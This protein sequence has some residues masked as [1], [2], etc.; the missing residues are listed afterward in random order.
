ML[1]A[2]YIK[3]LGSS[4]ASAT[5]EVASRHAKTSSAYISAN[6]DAF[7][8]VYSTIKDPAAIRKN[9]HD[10]GK[11]LQNS[12]V[13]QAAE[14][15]ISNSLDTIITGKFYD[16]ERA[17]KYGSMALGMDM[18]FDDMNDTG[19]ADLDNL[20][21]NVDDFNFDEVDDGSKLV[22]STVDKSAR[23]SAVVISSTVANTGKAI[24]QSQK[25]ST[26][27]MAN[28]QA[29]LFSG[30]QM[31]LGEIGNE[32]KTLNDV[33][34]A[35]AKSH[36]EASKT[37]YETS[38]KLM[39]DQNAMIK[40]M[41][42]MQKMTAGGLEKENKKK[43][44]TTYSDLV[45]A[46]GEVNIGEYL[47]QVGN[48]F[49][50]ILGEV[51]LDLS[52][53]ANPLMALSAN[54][55]AFI[56]EMIISSAIGPK[57]S[58]S[59]KN[60]DKS[61]SGVFGTM[62]GQMNRM[63]KNE[64]ST[65]LESMFGK[66]FGVSTSQK[67]S[68]ELKNFKKGPVP[69]DSVA[70]N[71]LVEVIP[72]YLRRIESAIVG[73]NEILYDHDS[74]KWTNIE[75]VKK[76]W[77]NDEKNAVS[78]A[79]SDIKDYVD[80]FKRRTK[81]RNKREE[82]E[83][84]E[85]MIRMFEKIYSD[86]VF[87]PNRLSDT[88]YAD[89]GVK[90]ESL[91]FMKMLFN[92]LPKHL[93]MTLPGE[94]LE[95]KNRLTKSRDNMEQ[96][97]SIA[98]LLFDGYSTR[99][100]KREGY[101]KNVFKK[102]LSL[103]E[104]MWNVN[105]KK[106]NNAHWYMEN[107][108]SEMRT[109]RHTGMAGGPGNTARRGGSR[110]ATITYDGPDGRPVS[111]TVDTHN[112]PDLMNVERRAKRTPAEEYRYQQMMKEM[113]Y[114]EDK[115]RNMS[116]YDGRR[117]I[118][119]GDDEK[120]NK[121][122]SRALIQELVDERKRSEYNNILEDG[123]MWLYNE[124]RD[125]VKNSRNRIQEKDP[126]NEK[127][128]VSFVR[129]LREAET[130]GDKYDV[131]VDGVSKIL[132]K[133]S[134]LIVKTLEM[135]DENIY[136][137][138]YGKETDK[139]DPETG[140]PIHGFFDRMIFEMKESFRSLNNWID[141]NILDPLLNKLGVESFGD[142]LK[143]ITDRVF[144]EGTV[145]NWKENFFGENSFIGRTRDKISE[146]FQEALAVTKT[147]VTETFKEIKEQILEDD[148]NPDTPLTPRKTP[149]ERKKELVDKYGFSNQERYANLAS[150][151]A[152]EKIA[153]YQK[154]IDNVESNTVM[155]SMTKKEM[156]AN[157]EKKIREIENAR[158][159]GNLA[160]IGESKKTLTSEIEE[161]KNDK[162]DSE[163]Y[164][165]AKR[166]EELI[167]SINDSDR[168]QS[169]KDMLIRKVSKKYGKLNSKR[170]SKERELENLSAEEKRIFKALGISGEDELYAND[171]DIV[172]RIQN[173]I[174]ET[175]DKITNFRPGVETR[176]ERD[177]NGNERKVY[178]SHANKEMY[179]EY[180]Q[181]LAQKKELES[182]MKEYKELNNI[183]DDKKDGPVDLQTLL[184]NS[185][186][187]HSKY[188]VNS[189][190]GLLATLQKESKRVVGGSVPTKELS[191]YQ[192]LMSLMGNGMP[193]KE[194]LL[195]LLEDMGILET[196]DVIRELE[197]TKSLSA[198]QNLKTSDIKDV[199]KKLKLKSIHEKYADEEKF[200]KD[201]VDER[202]LSK[203]GMFGPNTT[204]FGQTA[205]DRYSP[206]QLN[207]DAV[208]DAVSETTGMVTETNSILKDIRDYVKSIYQK[209]VPDSILPD[210][211]SHAKGA[212]YVKKS[213]LTAISEGEMIIPSEMNPFNPNKDKVNKQDE[214]RNERRIKKDY[215][216]DLAKEIYQNIR[217]NA[218]GQQPINPEDKVPADKKAVMTNTTFADKVLDSYNSSFNLISEGLFGKRDKFNVAMDDIKSK[219]S[220]YLPGGIAGGLLGGVVGLGLGAPLVLAAGGASIALASQS[221]T[222]K[223][224]LF[225]EMGKDANG[226]DDRKGGFIGKDTQKIFNKYIPDLTKYGITGGL[227]GAVLGALGGPFGLIGGSLIGGSL[228][229][230]KNNEE[231][232]EMFFGKDKGLINDD[233]KKFLKEKLPAATA[234]VVGSLM[235]GSPFGLIGGSMLG[236]GIGLV[237][238]TDEFKD[239]MFGP[240]AADGVR[241]GGLLGDLKRFFV[242]PLAEI[243]KSI[244]TSFMDILRNR[245]VEPLSR[246]IS[247]LAKDIQLGFK[248]GFSTVKSILEHVFTST[249][250]V[251][252]YKMLEKPMKWASN[253][254]FNKVTKAV[255]TG[256]KEFLLSPATIIG[257]MGDAS[258]DRHIAR[259]QADYMTAAERLDFRTQE[260]DGY[261]GKF[262]RKKDRT[263]DNLVNFDNMLVTSNKDQLTEMDDAFKKIIQG[264]K[265]ISSKKKDATNKLG[266]YVSSVVRDSGDA[267][268]IIR[269]FHA[270]NPEEAMRIIDSLDY[271][272]SPEKQKLFEEASKLNE[273]LNQVKYEEQNITEATTK[274]KDTLNNKFNLNLTSKN[275]DRY[276]RYVEVEKNARISDEDKYANATDPV[277]AVID[278]QE[279]HTE[280]VA[281]NFGT[282][283]KILEDIRAGR[284]VLT[285]HQSDANNVYN[286]RKNSAN[287][288]FLR[289]LQEQM[290]DNS[291]R[292]S[293][294]YKNNI[295]DHFNLVDEAD[296]IDIMEDMH[297]RGVQFNSKDINKIIASDRTVFDRMVELTELGYTVSVDEV[298]KLTDKGYQNVLAMGKL[299][300]RFKDGDFSKVAKLDENTMK[301]IQKM[302]SLGF[303][304]RNL[305]LD[306][307]IALKGHR[308]SSD[309]EVQRA[310]KASEEA[311]YLSNSQ[312]DLFQ[313]TNATIHHNVINPMDEFERTEIT[314]L[315]NKLHGKE[316]E[317]NTVND[318]IG[319]RN[320]RL[321]DIQFK[322]TNN[323]SSLD[324][325]KQIIKTLHERKVSDE[326][327]QEVL[328]SLKVSKTEGRELEA[329][330]ASEMSRSNELENTMINAK[331]NEE[332]EAA[333]REMIES[334]RNVDEAI[335]RLQVVTAN[336]QRYESTYN[337][338]LEKNAESDNQ[339]AQ[340]IQSNNNLL[341]DITESK[342]EFEKYSED[343]KEEYSKIQIRQKEL[344]LEVLNLKNEYVD[345]TSN[346]TAILNS[347]QELKD[348]VMMEDSA[349]R[350]NSAVDA[351][352][353]GGLM[354]TS[355]DGSLVPANTKDAEPGPSKVQR[356]F[357]GIGSLGVDG[358]HKVFGDIGGKELQTKDGSIIHSNTKD[359]KEAM[360]KQEEAAQTQKT[361]AE[362]LG[363]VANGLVGVGG[364]VGEGIGKAKDSLLGG[365]F[366]LLSNTKS[367]PGLLSM[368]ALATGNMGNLTSGILKMFK[369][370]VSDGDKAA[371]DEFDRRADEAPGRFG[372]R[373]LKSLG[374]TGR[375][376][377][378]MPRMFGKFVEPFEN[379]A[380]SVV[381]TAD[382][383]YTSPHTAKIAKFV[384]ENAK[385]V[386]AY[387]G[388][389]VTSV[390]DKVLP[391]NIKPNFI[392]A[393]TDGLDNAINKVSKS[394]ILQ[395]TMEH[396]GR[397]FKV[398][399]EKLQTFF[400]ENVKNAF[401]K[402]STKFMQGIKS[403]VIKGP[404]ASVKAFGRVLV[405]ASVFLTP[406]LVCWDFINGWQDARNTFGIFEEP[407][408]GLQFASGLIRALNGFYTF[409]LVPESFVIDLVMDYICKPLGYFKELN[410]L[411]ARANKQLAEYNKDKPLDQQLSHKGF[412][413]Q[414]QG[415]K[416][417]GDSAAEMFETPNKD[418]NKKPGETTTANNNSDTQ[419]T[420][421]EKQKE[422]TKSN[423]SK[424]VIPD[425]SEYGAGKFGMG[426]HYY[427]HDPK[428]NNVSYNANYD[429]MNQT[430]G[431]SGC[432]VMAASQIFSDT[433]G[434]DVDPRTLANYAVNN[435]YKEPNGGT[436]P[437]FFSDVFSKAGIG[438]N[439]TEDKKSMMDNLRAGKQTILMGTGSSS[440]TPFGNNPHY[441]VGKGIDKNGNIII[442]D[443]ESRNPYQKYNA[444]NVMKGVS[445]GVNTA[446]RFGQGGAGTSPK[447]IANAIAGGLIATG[448]EGAVDS[449]NPDDMGQPSIGISQW[450]DTRAIQLLK[451]IPGGTEFIPDMGMPMGQYRAEALAKVLANTDKQQLA[452][453]A[454]DCANN[455]LP[456]LAGIPGL[457]NGKCMVY[458]GMW[459]PTST[460]LVR[461]FVNNRANRF[462][463]NN[464]DDVHRMFANEYE[465][466]A[467]V[468]SYGA[469]P[470]QT[471]EYC[472]KLPDDLSKLSLSDFKSMAKSSGVSS[473]KSKKPSLFG[474]LDGIS[475]KMN[476]QLENVMAP[477]LTGLKSAF[478]KQY[479]GV[480]SLIFGDENG[481]TS[482]GSTS[483]TG[484][485]TT[486][487]QDVAGS[488]REWFLTNTNG[489]IT[490]EYQPEGRTLNGVT[491]PH[492]GIDIGIAENTNIPAPFDATVEFVKEEPGGYGNYMQIKDK[493]DYTHLFAHLND[494]LVNPGDKIKK[495]EVFAK[496]GNTG[497]STG[498]HLHYEVAKPDGE[499]IDPNSYNV[500]PK[501]GLGKSAPNAIG[502]LKEDKP[503]NRFGV[504]GD[505]SIDYTKILEAIVNLLVK[506]STNTDTL[507]QIVTLLSQQ[508]IEAKEDGKKVEVKVDTKKQDTAIKNSIKGLKDLFSA[509][510]GPQSMM[511]T[512]ISDLLNAVNV[513]TARD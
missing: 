354:Y 2:N 113:S 65:M 301:H 158:D 263:N 402:F 81:F 376:S 309:E 227:G 101:D 374:E 73:T 93:A 171:G 506:I 273:E 485:F 44:R 433:T 368:I 70:R 27:F 43:K 207:T 78:S 370:I 213:G 440:T 293:R 143:K 447:E 363:I 48:N 330:K 267:K 147:S 72:G 420:P 511:Q 129:R 324:H 448:V 429:G 373:A 184:S 277:K 335:K 49:N 109:M 476:Q 258:R 399:V 424:T 116:G 467:D 165:K 294:M 22:S 497:S 33:T 344:E 483:N 131:V 115:A 366:G 282:V 501:S 254:L 323:R 356:V 415:V 401:K 191:M 342:K 3:N 14:A 37:F 297:K 24:I 336:T 26:N 228:A 253:V 138:F 369:S 260:R 141:T 386:S 365:L 285:A 456:A 315:S 176:I 339:I 392:K 58:Q 412:L 233:R 39:T 331:T 60:F 175:S 4:V 120:M 54:P 404:M 460:G 421:A 347:A 8:L 108:L 453:L 1:I 390:I 29:K 11:V 486:T 283:I 281:E 105:D 180:Q 445:L 439:V 265:Y 391:D 170:L 98:K 385:K 346:K 442:Q 154:L 198:L 5:A 351:K 408:I 426:K 237:A 214:I 40:E 493:K 82:D 289:P 168:P 406:I 256:I 87:E 157:Y 177:A 140:R 220:S 178:T 414:E 484:K 292:V 203:D 505:G 423:Q 463:I 69:F 107:T 216:K 470:Q 189:H 299:G 197:K 328:T 153:I 240:A 348:K 341:E 481:T 164:S 163:T 393:A 337:S 152:S 202:E 503:K 462:D 499:S 32:L 512:E 47:G 345:K 119:F 243:G 436:M 509:V 18:S 215:S 242:D 16:E 182:E 245:I 432:G 118:E 23:A 450:R 482:N 389:H 498:P 161:L 238:T 434:K 66:L 252:F 507:G 20:D 280:V 270:Q 190:A 134:Q 352:T 472:K 502:R 295:T 103:A 478:D 430:L 278:S 310:L 173:H 255:G 174:Q 61:L 75:E 400:P 371:N 361:I 10:F 35:I 477:A 192:Q 382:D 349:I 251:P 188:K 410:E 25:A 343:T 319:K 12:K 383:I 358:T 127:Q 229:F 381:K 490:S 500:G 241:T 187:L 217:E 186:N 275:I 471:Y 480:S 469:R 308:F 221:N 199:I 196:D 269:A 246:A 86:G 205:A 422:V 411:R 124:Y 279:K 166:Y 195:Q 271:L 183:S 231:M 112:V 326:E 194:N 443:P 239:A 181:L 50:S 387:V 236:A 298:S 284:S 379:M 367:L 416:T 201:F 513:I 111:V 428:Y 322:I 230:I 451:S 133:P 56:P 136:T 137:F 333:L 360:D 325:N 132:E 306:D 155:N 117:T 42:D 51:G 487:I 36:A 200:N 159:N 272:Q 74:R 31:G 64:N 327:I 425:Y 417:W 212:R 413:M 97:D 303:T 151:K 405:Q 46:S 206:E 377:T 290:A 19:G 268:R 276:S 353:Y 452:Q 314:P 222:M 149:E 68:L 193:N 45:G 9:L 102:P 372:V 313:R 300:F 307:M 321:E 250:G 41:L 146:Y 398:I 437:G 52:G 15:T 262:F 62:I 226:E 89:Y 264:E 114:D 28:H 459:M 142:G 84:N 464:L 59:L 160:G 85:D 296:R 169:E 465:R 30:L 332:R 185:L 403:A 508:G 55:L 7:K 364:K 100:L 232:S 409:G 223:D 504:G 302:Y 21:F 340:L 510:K 92:S 329:L 257:A 204:L 475:S 388:E 211:M 34:V 91:K 248:S 466:A 235:L 395:S 225:G 219:V 334:K 438:S 446:S 145:D 104:Q 122:S 99:N 148:D 79:F 288:K 156:I 88:A 378:L 96:G 291:L 305:S 63:A 311:N 427:Q 491:K 359:Y 210:I 473:Q 121:A 397:I 266:R 162:S 474:I 394:R 6:K 244:K 247:P 53:D 274:A 304:Q 135:A 167:K 495:G 396:T 126:K 218:D 57:I 317:L 418:N 125:N 130:L 67:S 375:I 449:V 431:T 224:F 441:V 355:N 95:Q 444:M 123:D 458:I 110:F 13:Y 318:A 38:M 287:N 384:S 461:D 488:A 83:F 435:G 468:S 209:I 179:E 362:R 457:S 455:Y 338:L 90:E 234:G 357:G 350:R 419:K 106:G 249:L 380:H 494:V 316:Q 150:T 259:G 454:D 71:S 17:N 496:S 492:N 312:Y 80:A 94:I 320:N 144:G 139:V 76:S 407:T 489:T 479:G 286:E 172:S 208:E 261:T 77:D 128:N